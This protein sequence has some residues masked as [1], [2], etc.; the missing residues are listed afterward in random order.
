[1]NRL[2][3]GGEGLHE[4]PLWAYQ[5]LVLT[6]NIPPDSIIKLKCVER[7]GFVSGAFVHLVR[8]FDPASAENIATIKDFKTLDHH[9]ELI[10]YE[11]YKEKASEKV[12]LA[13]CSYQP[14]PPASET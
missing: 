13:P 12:L 6:L 2:W 14:S 3:I 8:I 7:M 1:M 9:P 10:L 11:G 5:Y 4:M